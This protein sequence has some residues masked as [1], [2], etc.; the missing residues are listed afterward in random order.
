MEWNVALRL[1]ILWCVMLKWIVFMVMAAKK[2]EHER[3]R[4]RVKDTY[5]TWI[6]WWSV[7]FAADN[8]RENMDFY[9]PTVRSFNDRA[10]NHSK[11]FCRRPHSTSHLFIPLWKKKKN[12]VWQRTNHK[13]NICYE[14]WYFCLFISHLR[15]Y[16]W[17]NKRP[18]NG[19]RKLFRF[20]SVSF[21]LNLPILPCIL[22]IVVIAQW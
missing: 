12:T 3:V 10:L 19:I 2:K 11:Y 21:Q 13:N 20:F 15:K 6:K 14:I 18:C 17:Q 9:V 16:Y 5:R 1:H 8:I 4:V 22:A 7:S